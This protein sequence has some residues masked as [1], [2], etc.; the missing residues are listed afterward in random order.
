MSKKIEKSIELAGRTLTLS[1]GHL[2]EQASGAVLAKYGETVVLATVVGAPL[3]KELDYFPLSVEYMEKLY[4]GGRIKGSRWV[5]R[6]GRPTDEEILTARLIDR[7]VR[8]LFPKTYKK[9]VQLILTVLSVDLENAPD[10]VAGIAASA[11]ISIS[12]IPWKGPVAI[13]RVGMH[14]DKYVANP[15]ATELETSKMDLIVSATKDAV[16]MIEAGSNEVTEKEMQGG[17]EF[18]EKESKTLIKFLEDFAKAGG[19]TKEKYEE[20]EGNLNVQKKVKE[21]AEP[22]MQDLIKRLATKEGLYTELRAQV[23]ALSA[24]FTEEEK[25]YVAKYFDDLFKKELRAM[26]LS[27]KRADGRKLNQIRDL[28]AEVGFLPRT[29]G[30]GLFQRGQTQVL[31]IATL[32]SPSNSQL[33]ESSR[34]EKDKRYIHQYNMPPFS[35]GEA[36]RVSGPGRR[37]IGHGALAER[38]LIPVIP[39]ENEFPYT[40]Q[41]VSEVLSSNGSTSMASVCG[42]T[43]SLMDAGVPIKTLVGGIAMG[44]IVESE[45]KYAVLTDIIGLE[46]FNGDMDFKVAGTKNGITALQLDVKTLSLTPKILKEAL[47]QAKEA[48]EEILGVIEK[49]IGKPR[50]TVSTYAP[51][52]KITKIDPSKIG[53]VVGGGGKTIKKIMAQTSTQV[54]IE[55]DGIVVV[56]GV[57]EEAVD[58]ALATIEGLVRE[59]TPGEVFDGEVKRVQPFGAFVEVLPG[60]EGLVH[61]S[62]MSEEYV[63]DPGSLVK[64]GDKVQ[65]RVIKVDDMGRLNLSMVMDPAF[66]QKKE[67]MRRERSGGESRESQGYRPRRNFDSGDRGGRGFSRGGDRGGRSYSGGASSTYDRP[68]SFDRGSGGGG[69][70]SFDR[71]RRSEGSR[72]SG[73]HFPA[74]RLMSSDKKFSR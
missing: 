21:L 9:E 29:H 51:K 69:G 1:T 35:T 64:E 61:V 6:D 31:S 24:E 58:R 17:I 5:K 40:I 4:A 50:A 73:P 48:R 44:L 70:R 36:G 68:R 57:N 26:V 28:S 53:E 46:D 72:S 18:A 7:S 59:L 62:D 34:G 65:V 15:Q 11:A 66:D 38:A 10:I 32:G 3:Q 23:D 54:D 45:D 55:D 30:S 74:S 47:S 14:E 12:D 33:L 60:K 41:V 52:I 8:P 63:S 22:G 20:P 49:A 25:P 67:E 27:G 42:S 19:K 16:V 39:S 37:E 2:A 71:P 13:V 43:L 56:S